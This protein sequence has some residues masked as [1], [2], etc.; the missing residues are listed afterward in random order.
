M[1]VVAELRGRVAG[2]LADMAARGLLRD[3]PDLARLTVEP[4]RDAAR[5]DLVVNAALAFGPLWRGAGPGTPALAQALAAGLARDSDLAR[6]AA[7]GAGFLNVTLA[8]VRLAAAASAVLAGDAVPVLGRAGE[9]VRVA[10]PPPAG[11]PAAGNLDHGRAAVVAD[12]LARL[13]AGTG[14]DVTFHLDAGATAFEDGLRRLGLTAPWATAAG[15][16]PGAAPS[17][18]IEVRSTEPGGKR[19]GPAA[20]G[21]VVVP[22][23]P[24]RLAADLGPGDP[25]ALRFAILC[26]ARTAPLRLDP[27]GAA[28]R[29]HA[30]PLFDVRY[31]HARGARML[32]MADDAGADRAAWGRALARVACAGDLDRDLLRAVALF[33]HAV[34]RALA[35]H[36]PQRVA[37]LMRD[38]SAAVHRHWYR[39]K[40]QPQL[41]F[42]NEEQRDLTRAR[43]GLMMASTIVLKSGLGLFGIA[44]PDE[45]R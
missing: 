32:R 25:D 38:L 10:A 33:P 18:A 11:R 16:A 45:M 6:V 3:G 12:A 19:A 5:G 26:R 36:E 4:C 8:T 35:E 34:E 39:S 37:A 7:A 40:D 9:P 31:A 42:V 23:A 14:H 30:G 41:R 29:S 43:L 1:D 28:D 20:P 24:C 22:V 2:L 15:R 13:L 17:R 44:A 21:T 27:A